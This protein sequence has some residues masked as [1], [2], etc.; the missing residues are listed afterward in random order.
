MGCHKVGIGRTF[1]TTEATTRPIIAQAAV[2]SALSFDLAIVAKQSTRTTSSSSCRTSVGGSSGIKLRHV[3]YDARS[4]GI[5]NLS[6]QPHIVGQPGACVSVGPDLCDHASAIQNADPPD[7][8]DVRWH[9]RQDTSASWWRDDVDPQTTET[10]GDRE[11]TCP[12]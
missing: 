1:R 4:K 7:V 9:A 6:G 12:R 8:V 11:R 3:K 10:S 5:S 2:L